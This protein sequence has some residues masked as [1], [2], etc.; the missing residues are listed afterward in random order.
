MVRSDKIEL[1]GKVA[2][3]LKRSQSVVLTDFKGMTVAELMGLRTQLRGQSIEM[4]VIKSPEETAEIEKAVDTSVDMHL[5]AMRMVRPG[6]TESE[7]AARVT[8]PRTA[9]RRKVHVKVNQCN[10]DHDSAP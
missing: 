2:E 8:E 3:K 9:R 4:R 6:M 10:V 1:V 5:A 7:V